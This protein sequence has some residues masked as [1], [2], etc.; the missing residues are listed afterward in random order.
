MEDSEAGS[1]EGRRNTNWAKSV[2]GASWRF[3]GSRSHSRL[4]TRHSLGEMGIRRRKKKRLE[5][6]T[7]WKEV[8]TSPRRNPEFPDRGYSTRKQDRSFW[9]VSEPDLC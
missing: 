2:R 5:E 9:E 1:K 8:C 6:K 4:L 7:K 3:Q